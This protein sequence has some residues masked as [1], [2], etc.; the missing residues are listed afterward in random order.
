MDSP[1]SSAGGNE[2]PQEST[3]GVPEG[4]QGSPAGG[5]EGSREGTGAENQPQSGGVENA[6]ETGGGKTGGDQEKQTGTPGSGGSRSIP[7]GGAFIEGTL[8]RRVPNKSVPCYPLLYL[9]SNRSNVACFH[10]L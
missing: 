3:A 7:E 9:N 5:N 4:K 1:G 6:G 10:F 2:G 8:P